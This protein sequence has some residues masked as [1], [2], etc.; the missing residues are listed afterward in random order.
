MGYYRT[1]GR[2]MPEVPGSNPDVD[3]DF[4]IVLSC[5]DGT[6]TLVIEDLEIQ[7]DSAVADFIFPDDFTSEDQTIVTGSTSC[8]TILISD[9]VGEPLLILFRRAWSQAP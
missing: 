2:F 9:G 6:A 8:P 7:T 3:A 5:A 4:D 1:D